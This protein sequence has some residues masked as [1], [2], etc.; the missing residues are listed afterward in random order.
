MP[1]RARDFKPRTVG[2]WR[3]FQTVAQRA[4]GKYRWTVFSERFRKAHPLCFDPYRVHYPSYA[5][6]EDVHHIIPLAA[7]PDLVYDEDN[8]A[9][10]CRHCHGRLEGAMKSGTPTRRLFEKGPAHL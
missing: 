8:C 9:A 6:S 4:R 2:T 5:P 7:R 3:L 1:R 10:V